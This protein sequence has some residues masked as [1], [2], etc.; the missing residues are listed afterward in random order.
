M[1]DTIETLRFGVSQRLQTKRG[2]IENRRIIDYMNFDVWTYYYPQA[3]RDNFG[4][5]FGQTQYQ[6]EWYI[7]DRTSIV[8]TGWFDFFDILGDPQ[9]YTGGTP[10]NNKGIR[11]I[12]GRREHEPAAAGDG[13]H[14]LLDHQ[15]R[16]DHRRRP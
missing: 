7:G 5:P 6:Y 10:V 3:S 11:V 9:D 12:I 14:R 2:P 16:A 4:M 13:L 15:H 8:S 1:Q